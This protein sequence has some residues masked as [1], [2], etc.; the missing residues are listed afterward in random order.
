MT[1]FFTPFLD[2][3]EQTAGADRETAG[4]VNSEMCGIFKQMKS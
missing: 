4:T 3:E 1:F 2:P